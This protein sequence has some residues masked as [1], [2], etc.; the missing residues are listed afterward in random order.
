M[1]QIE[2][3]CEIEIKNSKAFCRMV[4]GSGFLLFLASVLSKPSRTGVS[5]NIKEITTLL[6][7]DLAT[8]EI[9]KCRNPILNIISKEKMS[10]NTIFSA[11]ISFLNPHAP[12]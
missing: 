6:R 2:H 7:K 11:V 12:R 9:Y 1:K 4:L 3:D 5:L 8:G 10:R